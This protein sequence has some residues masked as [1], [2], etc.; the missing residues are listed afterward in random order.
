MS[1][2]LKSITG[3]ENGQTFKQLDSCSIQRGFQISFCKAIGTIE[4][5]SLMKMKIFV[6]CYRSLDI[7]NNCKVIPVQVQTGP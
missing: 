7:E 4:I 3:S 2:T 5:E 1:L 6:T